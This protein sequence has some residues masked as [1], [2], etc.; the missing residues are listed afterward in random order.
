MTDPDL[1]SLSTAL[2]LAKATAD[3][4]M[5]LGQ[6]AEL[7]TPKEPGYWACRECSLRHPCRTYQLVMAATGSAPVEPITEVQS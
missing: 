6:I 2:T 3:L 7:H 1:V 4:S 5:R